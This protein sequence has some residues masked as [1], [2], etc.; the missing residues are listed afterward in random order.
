MASLD[1]IEGDLIEG[2]VLVIVV[3]F[4]VA[5]IAVYRSLGKLDPAQAFKNALALLAGLWQNAKDALA[6][7]VSQFNG[8]GA[9]QVNTGSNGWG[10]DDE[11][12]YQDE[13]NTLVSSG[14]ITL[15]DYQA[16]M[17]GGN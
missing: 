17:A 12:R 3:V 16:Y 5:L 7:P 11:A 13:M 10:S 4:I 14:Q 6:I 15:A 1:N 9:A 2:G 8:G